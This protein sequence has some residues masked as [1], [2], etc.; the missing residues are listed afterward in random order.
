ME[1]LF[2]TP[3]VIVYYDTVVN[4]I[5][6]MVNGLQAQEIAHRPHI[7]VHK[8]TML[9]KLQ[10]ELGAKGITCAKISE[11]EIMV[12]AGIQDILIANEII[13]KI[14]LD[15]LMVLS[16]RANIITCV[17]SI[18]GATALSEAALAVGL[19]AKV[20][21]EINIGA[22]RCGVKPENAISFV[23]EVAV[24]NGIEIIGLMTYSGKIY[25]K[26]IGDEMRSESAREPRIL[27]AIQNELDENGIHLSVLS[28]GSSLSSRYPEELKGITE[29]RAGNYI[30]NDCT[31]LYSGLCT[32]DEC[33]LRVISTITSI[34]EKGRFIIDAGSKALT[35]DACAYGNGFGYVVEYPEMEIYALNEEHGYIR[36]ANTDVLKIGQQISIIPNHTCVVPNVNEEVMGIK[37]DG[38]TFIIP[39]E[40]RGKNK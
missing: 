9:A 40:A 1:E 15:K 23:K 7:K 10:I 14:K 3:A 28:A 30:Y 39:V 27:Y 34:P 24:L 33:A 22:D 18:D 4:N 17:D 6:K 5:K 11:A 36:Y 37:A 32:V 16:K 19:K 25:G 29:S 38:T 35:S 20:Y 2:D 21:I 12:D 13:G 31:G 26:K 8:S